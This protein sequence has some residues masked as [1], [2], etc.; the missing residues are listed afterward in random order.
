MNEE[1]NT[2]PKWKTYLK[3]MLAFVAGTLVGAVAHDKLADMSKTG[4]KAGIE[5]K[6]YEIQE[7]EVNYLQMLE[8]AKGET[9]EIVN[10]VK[11]V[12]ACKEAYPDG[13][14]IVYKFSGY[15]GEEIS[16]RAQKFQFNY[17]VKPFVSKG[18]LTFSGGEIA[19]V[20]L[21]PENLVVGVDGMKRII[22]AFV[23]PQLKPFALYA[24]T[25]AFAIKELYSNM[26]VLKVS[27]EK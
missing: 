2:K 25:G 4:Q 24:P 5:N 7:L 20:L 15:I 22:D 16:K 9:F 19:G 23:V 12:Y 21:E 1:I 10:G 27:K 8:G 13:D 26:A 6:D 3:L 17:N 14:R 11:C 18:E